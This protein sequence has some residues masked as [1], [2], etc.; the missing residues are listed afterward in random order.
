MNKEEEK[1]TNVTNDS[2]SDVNLILSSIASVRFDLN[3]FQV[4]L[5]TSFAYTEIFPPHRLI[6]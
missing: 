2:V 6:E 1:K 4:W 5:V 3:D